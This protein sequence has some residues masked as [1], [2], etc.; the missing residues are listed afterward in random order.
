[1]NHVRELSTEVSKVVNEIKEKIPD[2]YKILIS[3]WNDS[4]RI[5]L[6]DKNANEVR[7]WS[8]YDT[9]GLD[10]LEH[11]EHA[12]ELASDAVEASAGGQRRTLRTGGK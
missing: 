1:M 8:D 6:F 9:P 7:V 10:L 12:I 11:F 2:G 4:Y 5:E 3:I